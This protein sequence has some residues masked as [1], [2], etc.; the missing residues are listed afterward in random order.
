MAPVSLVV[1]LAGIVR[2]VRRGS[3]EREFAAWFCEE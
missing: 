2:S 1:A 3:C